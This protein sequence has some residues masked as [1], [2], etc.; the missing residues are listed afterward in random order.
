MFHQAS[1][2][3]KNKASTLGTPL[4]VSRAQK[5]VGRSLEPETGERMSP[6]YEGLIL[7]F[8]SPLTLEKMCL[9]PSTQAANTD[10]AAHLTR[11]R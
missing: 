3:E 5:A 1:A 7:R 11:C 9:L 10:L 6:K 2:T 4:L 8:T